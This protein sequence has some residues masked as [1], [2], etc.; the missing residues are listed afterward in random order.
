MILQNTEVCDSLRNVIEEL[1]LQGN[2]DNWPYAPRAYQILRAF[3]N[4]KTSIIIIGTSPTKQLDM[5][6]GLSFSAGRAESTCY[7]DKGD[8]IFQVHEALREA[9]ILKKKHDYNC[10]HEECA[11]NEVLLLNA[12][13]TMYLHHK[14]SNGGS[15]WKHFLVNLL[16]RWIL[17]AKLENKVSI[18]LWDYIF[19]ES[20]KR[21]ATNLWGG[22]N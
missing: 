5:E 19:E 9:G 6:N 13:M 2:N 8:E 1:E 4:L 20:S 17:D 10:G 21:L 7:G 15:L 16:R 22:G 18:M 12:T 11:E 14:K 3:A